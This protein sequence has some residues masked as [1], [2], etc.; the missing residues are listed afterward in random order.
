MSSANAIDRLLVGITGASGAIYGVRVLEEVARRFD[1]IYLM[2]SDA[3]RQVMRAE[4]SLSVGYGP[5][6]VRVLLGGDYPNI[7]LLS[8]NE[9]SSPPASGSFR[10]AGMIIAP[11]S[12]GTAG[13]IA[14]SISD[15]LMT[16][17]ADVCLKEGRKLV[18]VIRETPWSLVHLRNLTQ[19]AEAGAT[20]LPAAPGFY[21]Q[22]KTIDDLVNH[23][24]ARVLQQLHLEQNL[25]PE[26]SVSEE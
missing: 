7:T 4:L 6:A 14:H 13:R 19:L 8:K 26:W 1:E 16:R 10:N 9:F 24:V 5:E 2:I 21:H 23:V 18:L 12:M 15:D 25:A 17:A 22:P 3:A 20:I 11:C